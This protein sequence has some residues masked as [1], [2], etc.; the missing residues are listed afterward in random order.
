MLSIARVAEIIML[1]ACGLCAGVIFFYAVERLKLWARMPIDQYMADF[2]R[3]L[4]RADPLQPMMG[5]TAMI[6]AV[7]F[8]L[9]VASPAS[10]LA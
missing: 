2:R 1:V 4:Y 5:A 7:V 3:S 9:N 8:A 6:A 10:G